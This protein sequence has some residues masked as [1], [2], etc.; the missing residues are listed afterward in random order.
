[1]KIGKLQREK[2][3]KPG[4]DFQTMK[5]WQDEARSALRKIPQGASGHKGTF[6]ADVK[7]YLEYVKPTLAPPTYKSRVCELDAY[8]AVFRRVPRADITKDDLQKLRTVWLTTGRAKR[9]GVT[10]AS[11]KTVRNRELALHHLYRVLDGKKAAT[12]LD[13]LPPLPK[14]PADP[15][16]VSVALIKRVAARLQDPLTRAWFMV[17][18]STGQRPAQ[19]RRHHRSDVN[20]R[21]RLWL[22]RPAKGGNPIPVTLTDDMIAAFKALRAAGGYKD[23]GSCRSLDGSDYAK[24]LYAAGWPKHIRPYNAKHTV[25]IALGESGAEWEDIKDYFGHTDVKTTRIY[26]GLIAARGRRTSKHLEGRIGW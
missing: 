12:P 19:L 8:L 1:V 24:R 5:A 4:A 17:L 21:R 20:F 13:D 15:R 23:D 16:F 3:Y 6:G 25:A 14:T 18:T 9:N 2:R 11:T 26:T 22:V 10:G 7:A